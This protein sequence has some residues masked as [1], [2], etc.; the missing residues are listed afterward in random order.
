MEAATIITIME[1]IAQ[2]AADEPVIVNAVTSVAG[3]IR[4]G[5]A[6]TPEQQASIDLLLD[7]AHARLQGKAPPAETPAAPPAAAPP[8]SSG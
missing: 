2:I 8:A 6:P 1:A 4:S 7:T 5:N 3:I